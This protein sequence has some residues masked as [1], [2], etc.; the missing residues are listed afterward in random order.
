M[1]V[2]CSEGEHFIVLVVDL[3][4]FVQTFEGVECSMSPV[5]KRI[6]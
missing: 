5:E 2:L 4:H 6:I 1:E 3:M